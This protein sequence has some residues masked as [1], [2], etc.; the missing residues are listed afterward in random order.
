MNATTPAVTVVIS[1]RDRWPL[2][3]RTALAATLFQED[4]DLEVIIVDDGSV[5]GPPDALSALDDPRVRIVRHPVTR[6]VAAARNTGIHEARGEWLAFL[7]DDDLWAPTKLREQITAAAAA[8]AG[9]VYAGAVWVDEG[10]GLIHG[11]A[12]PPPEAVERELLRWNVLWGGCSN[13]VAR[14][15]LLESLGGFDERL[16]QLADWDLWIR[17]SLVAK[18]AAIED[19][20]VALVMHPKSMLLVDRRDVFVEFGYL[21]EKHRGA[22]E[23]AHVEFDRA[24]FAR[25]VAGG[26]LRAGRRRA[27]ARAYVRGTTSPGNLVRAVGALLSPSLLASASSVRAVVPGALPEGERVAERPDWL[28]LYR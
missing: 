19:V 16:F 27:A 2:V 13:V 14:R 22:C 7:D 26:H 11:H 9:F 5:D 21:V 24:R 3:A 28:D 8:G 17:L 23:R 6:G 10:L 25:W 1:T 18:A 4:V 12:P 15:E 20:L